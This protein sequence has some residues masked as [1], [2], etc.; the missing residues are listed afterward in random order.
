MSP[1]NAGNSGLVMRRT[2]LEKN[3]PRQPIAG[4]FKG[5]L[6]KTRCEPVLQFQQLSCRNGTAR[7]TRAVTVR[8]ARLHPVNHVL[9]LMAP[10]L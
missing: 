6:R 8:P 1:S 9:I 5:S 2:Q 4:C 7:L 3:R 10:M